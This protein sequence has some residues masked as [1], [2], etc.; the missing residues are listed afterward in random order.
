M[1]YLGLWKNKILYFT[2]GS[3]ILAALFSFN[4][5]ELMVLLEMYEDTRIFIPIF[6]LYTMV[7][8]FIVSFAFTL[9]LIANLYLSNKLTTRELLNELLILSLIILTFFQLPLIVAFTVY[10]VMQ[11][12]LKVL[13]QEYT[14]LKNSKSMFSVRKFIFSLAPFSLMAIFFLAI[15]FV[16]YSLGK[17]PVSVSLLVFILISTITIPHSIVMESF[18][19]SEIK[20]IVE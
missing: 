12:S 2:W 10:F 7:I 8:I 1:T 14:F 4:H 5:G 20:K 6:D 18:Y 9:F 19:S 17:L 11:H 3:A 16:L 15:L 13:I